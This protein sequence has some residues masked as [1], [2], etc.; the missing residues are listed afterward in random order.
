VTVTEVQIGQAYGIIYVLGKHQ[1]LGR[2]MEL[3][4]DAHGRLVLPADL[5][6]H[7]GLKPGDEVV[8][9]CWGGI[10]P[11]D[12]PE[13]VDIIP[14]AIWLEREEERRKSL[15]EHGGV[16]LEVIV[17]DLNRRMMEKKMTSVKCACGTCDMTLFLSPSE[18]FQKAPYVL[19]I[20]ED[21][22]PHTAFFLSK[23]S[24]KQLINDLERL[25]SDN[26]LK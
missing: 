12:K 18:C 6:A 13:E 4:V 8:T 14:K 9:E 16:P 15:E 5:M 20:Y 11:D 26:G 3:K 21:C 25:L 24:I 23:E 7:L 10:L 17:E 1:G 22:E 19:D 2:F